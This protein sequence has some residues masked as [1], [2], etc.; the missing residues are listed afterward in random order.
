MGDPSGQD[1]TRPMLDA[2][3]VKA[4]GEK[5]LAQV[6]RVLLPGFSV[7]RNH[8]WFE[9]MSV[10]VLLAKLASRFTVA[11][12]MARDGFKRRGGE[13]I[14][15]HELLVPMLQ[16]W[17]SVVLKSDLEIGGTDQLFNFQVARTLQEAEGQK[18]QR[19]LMTPVINGTDGRKM[20][21]SFGNCIFLDESPGEIFGKV[22]SVS[23]SVMAEW[24]P[25]L[26]DLTDWPEHPMKRKKALAF[27]IV[28]Q[29]HG[30]DA[31]REGQHHFEQK[32]EQGQA[33]DVTEVPSG[34]L[35]GIVQALRGCSKTQARRLLAGGSVRVDGER[36]VDAEFTVEP[37][38][39]IK[40]GKR[41][42]GITRS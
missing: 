40:V 7:H 19:C 6:E 21:K 23:D 3:T 37:G 11:S 34:P 17:D 32:I 42:W 27:D 18:A 9:A 35:L 16:G 38:L 5:I 33:L 26:S 31:A 39:R 41:C 13:G 15:V 2:D 24:I 28:K 4:N 29:I 30:E 14:A 12:M 1:K 20:S 36:Q 10:P 25:K 22:M 8:T